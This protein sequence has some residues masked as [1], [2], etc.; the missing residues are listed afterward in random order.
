ME[1]MKP[2]FNYASTSPVVIYCDEYLNAVLRSRPAMYS[3][4]DDLSVS[5]IDD[6]LSYRV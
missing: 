4:S 6:T 2:V 3:S 5:L 1:R